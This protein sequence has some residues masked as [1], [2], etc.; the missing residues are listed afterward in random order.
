MNP[1]TQFVTNDALTRKRWAREL[2]KELLPEVEFNYLIST[3]S[4]AIVEQRNDLSKGQGDEITFGIRLSLQG[5]G[6]VGNDVIEGYE[7]GLRF[8]NFKS[9]IEE[10][11]H[12]VDTGGKMDEQR[13][14]YNLM[15]EGKSALQDWWADK[16]SDHLMAHLCG[17][18]GLTIAGKVF[19]QAPTEPDTYHHLTVDDVAEASLTSANVLDLTFLDRLKQRAELPSG[20]G[21]KVRPLKMGGKNYFRVILHNY[22]FDQLRM[23][24]NVGQWGDLL[25]AAQKLQVPSTEIEYNGMLISKS[26]R[27]YS[28]YTNIYRCVLLGCQ[29]AVFAWGG[30]GESKSSTMAFHPYTRDADR[31]LMVRGG[32]IFGCKKVV[33]DSQDYGLLTGSSYATAIA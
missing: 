14:P 33:F 9:T 18:S 22:V 21:F 1:K 17:N 7:E 19:A 24:T 20:G 23:N 2:Y 13:I 5:E 12:A 4:G 32:G 10:L 27:V 26:E 31:F 29:A 16:L 15:T 8:R 30:A 3:G 6:R 28:P 11:Q 25:R